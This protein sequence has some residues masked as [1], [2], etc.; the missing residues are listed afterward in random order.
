MRVLHERCTD[1][2]YTVDNVYREWDERSQKA[3]E[4]WFITQS[5]GVAV[6]PSREKQRGRGKEKD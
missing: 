6:K 2:G 4:R 3:V 1:R 5:L